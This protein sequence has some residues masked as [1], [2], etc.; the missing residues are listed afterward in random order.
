MSYKIATS[1]TLALAGLTALAAPSGAQESAPPDTAAA[2]V[3]ALGEVIVLA[4]RA[5]VNRAASAHRWGPDR[6]RALD[7]R[8][9]EDALR[10]MPGLHFSRSSRNESTFRLRG[11]EQRQVGVF[12][13]GVP[14]SIPFDGVVDVSQLAGGELER[15]QVSHGFASLLYGA[16]ALGGAVNLMTRLPSSVP[17]AGLR[18]EVSNHGR[19]SGSGWASG[20]LGD[21]RLRAS[22]SFSVASSFSLPDGF[23]TTANEDGGERENSSH[24]KRQGTLRA[25]W[26]LGSAHRLALTVSAVDNAYDVPPN[27]VSSRARYWRFPEWRKRVVSLA[28]HHRLS[29]VGTLRAVVFHDGYENRLR[30]FDD[31]S[32]TTQRARYAFDSDYDDRSRGVHLLPTLHLLPGG[33]TDA[34]VAYRSDVHRQ[35][36]GSDPFERHTA[37]TLTLGLEQ[38]V[39]WTPR[40]SM[41]VGLGGA[42]LRPGADADRDERGFLGQVN[43]QFAT[44]YELGPAFSGHAAVSRKSRF[45]TLKEL[46]SSRL[47]RN[48]PN[49]G[50]RAERSVH[51]ELGVRASV[52]GWETGVSVFRSGLGDLITNV[53]AGDGMQQLRNLQSARVQGVEMDVSR[54]WSRGSVLMNYT[55]LSARNTAPD[56]AYLYLPYRPAHRV[57]LLVAVRPLPGLEVGGE[58]WF[59]GD[60]H[61][62]NPDDGRWERLEDVTWLNL[63]AEVTLPRRASVF[64]RMDNAL[65]GAHYSEYGVPLPGREVAAGLRVALGG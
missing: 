31:D 15:V 25:D 6:I 64:L 39:A 51:S 58:L 22:A 28:S 42:W 27:A 30:S 14:I 37:E 24:A 40:L 21:L 8:S 41:V 34:V 47:G 65:D 57:N 7:P 20:G 33:V 38:D 63:R 12:L 13:D 49:P 35:R 48:L 50:L 59:A 44:R 32:Y 16:N 29:G 19:R 17:G 54:D 1:A 46:Y 10:Y 11:F 3:F 5:P 2:P 23:E 52:G 56:R 4:E 36:N 18:M 53:A 60:Q 55:L 61:Y 45:P 43:G 62:E 26:P 9:A